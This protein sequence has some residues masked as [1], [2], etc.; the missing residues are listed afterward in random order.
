MFLLKRAAFEP[1]EVMRLRTRSP[2]P[3]RHVTHGSFTLYYE[4]R[5]DLVAR[6]D[7][8]VLSCHVDGSGYARQEYEAGDGL[9]VLLAATVNEPAVEIVT[10]AI[11]SRPIFYKR[12]HSA[13]SSHLPLLT[14]TELDTDALQYF[15]YLSYNPFFGRTLFRDVRQTLAG[16]MH[17]FA[18]GELTLSPAP[19]SVFSLVPSTET[20]DED[21][22]AETFDALYRAS[23]RRALPGDTAAA[24]HVQLS[25]GIDTR[26]LL[27]EVYRQTVGE[28]HSH[29][30][31]PDWFVDNAVARAIAARLPR[32]THHVYD[33]DGGN[34]LIAHAEDVVF[35]SS[36]NTRFDDVFRNYVVSRQ[37][38]CLGEP[39]LGALVID[40]LLGDETESSM[41]SRRH[42][43]DTAAKRIAHHVSYFDYQRAASVFDRDVV[44]RM[45]TVLRDHYAEMLPPNVSEV[46]G[47]DLL[48]ILVRHGKGTCGMFRGTEAYRPLVVPTLTRRMFSL[49]FSL[50]RTVKEGARGYIAYL[51]RCY[52][53]ALTDIPTTRQLAQRPASPQL[54]LARVGAADECGSH[55]TCGAVCSQRDYHFVFYEENPRFREFIADNVVAFDRKRLM[56]ARYEPLLSDVEAA[57]ILI[58]VALMN[59]ALD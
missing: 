36:L 41:S 7:G 40:S 53:P 58:T 25:G 24:L 9:Y 28:V 32:V 49:A 39:L 22:F 44:T 56:P 4:Q 33:F 10:D 17:R 19:S 6:R 14:P 51:Q 16:T 55:A 1:P 27:S 26:G 42:F 59:I 52:E 34:E 38:G 47:F 20:L 8:D 18:R 48:N 54:A 29:G 21:R 50:A 43:G 37:M 12:D 2:Y 23:I 5:P 15:L 35:H 46:D 3:I 11:N 57:R 30:Y 13:F 31:G 45:N